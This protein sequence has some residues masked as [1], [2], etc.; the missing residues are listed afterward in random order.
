MAAIAAHWKRFGQAVASTIATE[1]ANRSAQAQIPADIARDALW[2][3]T[4]V[5][6][7]N[8]RAL[9]DVGG[10]G[11]FPLLPEIP[12]KGRRKTLCWS[13]LI[14]MRNLMIHH[15]WTINEAIVQQTVREDFPVL[16]ALAASV[17]VLL[18][19]HDDPPS[20]RAAAIGVLPQ[21]PASII[22]LDRTIG[23]SRLNL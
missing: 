18:G 12:L 2:F 22:Y 16:H 1:A 9:Q 11:L 6:L 23:L 7:E 14:A 5:A 15:W 8:V 13:N 19:S 21:L 17:N 4:I 20:A 10:P 3:R